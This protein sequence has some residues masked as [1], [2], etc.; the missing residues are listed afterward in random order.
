MDISRIEHTIKATRKLPP[1]ER[2]TW[3]LSLPSA[4]TMAAARREATVPGDD[5]Q[6]PHFDGELYL[7][8]YLG[9][10][11]R[12]VRGLVRD[13]VVVEMDK[14]LDLADRVTWLRANLPS[15]W[16]RE[17]IQA[18]ESEEDVDPEEERSGS[19]SPR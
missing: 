13:G 8:A 7:F 14:D 1:E 12:G 11:V 17:L 2:C 5:G 16:A 15:R 18:A 10:I 6:P 19:A 4:D 3:T 9:R